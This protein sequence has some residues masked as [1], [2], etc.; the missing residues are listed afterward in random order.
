M[1]EQDLSSNSISQEELDDKFLEPPNLAPPLPG[2]KDYVWISY[3][4]D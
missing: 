4:S 1:S 3:D 2:V